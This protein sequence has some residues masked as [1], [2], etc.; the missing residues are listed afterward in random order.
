MGQSRDI[1]VTNSVYSQ[2][3]VSTRL[4]V[5]VRFSN[6]YFI[7]R[8]WSVL[9]FKSSLWSMVK[10]LGFVRM[11]LFMTVIFMSH[12]TQ[13]FIII[14]TIIVLLSFIYH[15]FDVIIWCCCHC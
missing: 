3:I 13:T 11:I 10:S 6:I 5:T 2:Y 4:Q 12:K 7:S 15:N 14:T 1:S 9:L 8:L